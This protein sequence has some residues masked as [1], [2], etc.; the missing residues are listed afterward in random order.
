MPKKE[1]ATQ[2]ELFT[3]E[4][5]VAN[6][7]LVREL[8]TN[9]GDHLRNVDISMI[10]IRPDRFNARI[11]PEGMNEE[12]W[13][14]ILMIPDLA[15]KIYANNGPIDPILG[16]FHNDG[17][18]YI[19]NGE[20]RFRAIW[21]LLNAGNEV[22]PNGDAIANVQVLLNPKGTTDLQRKK[23]MY[24]TND[25]LPF[26]PMQK[27]H[28]FLS[29]TQAPYNLTHD[30][31]GEEFKVSRQTIDN[32]IRAT[33]LSLE[34]QEQI[35]TGELKMTN[36]LGDIRK[37]KA[38]AK[39]KEGD[40]EPIITG[41]LADKQDKDKKEG[42]KIRGDEDEFE[43]EDNRVGSVGGVGRPKED[44]SSGSHTIGKDAIYMRQQKEALFKVFFN[45]YN[46]LFEISRKLIVADKPEDETDEERAPVLFQK[47]HDHT[48]EKLMNEYDLTVK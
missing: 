25:N 16:D 5:N 11:K 46:V 22:Y 29:F 47:R 19:N 43:M 23:R 4:G 37:E 45:R 9:P 28:F 39:N 7:N 17:N 44:N 38:A 12:M 27:A 34:L 42:E 40:D 35:D 8:S 33:T 6:R 3:I 20:R 10:A 2:A 36:V 15:E 32:Y 21:Y 14:Q 13:N 41:V 31:I 24:S 30:Q 26:T 48:L 1:T 18:F